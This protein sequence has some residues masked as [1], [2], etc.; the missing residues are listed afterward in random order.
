M[1]RFVPAV[2]WMLVIFYFSSRSTTGVI[3]SDPVGRFFVF[4]TFHLIEYAALAIFLFYALKQKF[5]SGAIAYL[6]SLTDEFHQLFTPGRSGKFTDTLFDLAGIAIGLVV[7][8]LLSR[9]PPIKK[10]IS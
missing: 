5:W 1:Y 3:T 6:Y 2:L 4:K 10:L 8:R 7:L 9:Y